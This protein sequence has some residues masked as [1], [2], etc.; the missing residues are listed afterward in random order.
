MSELLVE[1]VRRYS[2]SQQEAEAVQYLTSWLGGHGFE[3]WIDEAGNACGLRGDSN[4]P[5]LL[6]LLGHI[7]TFPGDIP[8]RVEDNC[9]FG[10]GSVDAKGS[11]CTFAEA[12]AEAVIPPG[13][14]VMVVG[15]VEEECPTSKGAHYV[16]GQYTPT[17]CIIGEP[18]SSDRITLGYKGR[19]IVD[20]S[21]SKPVSHTARP[22]PTVGALG[23]AFW[24]AISDWAEQENAG[25]ERYFDQVMATL[26]AIN[27]SSDYFHETLTMTVGFRLPPRLTPEEVYRVVSGFAPPGGRL[28]SYSAERAYQG[29]RGNPLVRGMMAA[30]RSEGGQPGFVLK[31]GTSDMNIVG[32]KWTC[33]MIAYGPGDSN[34]DHTPNEHLPLDEYRRAIRTLR[35]FIEY[36][37]TSV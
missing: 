21:L 28:W 22:E 31:T 13:W 37:P 9:V 25:V 32:V 15:A 24:K 20:Y 4:A 12:A 19:L 8:V 14:R 7:D 30:I 11:L 23:A 1:L 5:N 27:T 29:D 3:S 17:F 35:Y 16:R 36:L 10:R 2:P 33:P 6:I 26:R 34:L 18:S